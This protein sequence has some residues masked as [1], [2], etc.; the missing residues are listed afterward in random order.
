MEKILVIDD[1]KS[2][3]DLLSVVFEKEGYS[4][5]TSLSATKAV[6][7]MGDEDFDIIISDI[8]MPKMSG[9]ELL[10]YVRENR[11]DIPIV[12]ITAY[13]TIKQAVEALKAGA[14]DYIVKPFDVEELKIIVAQGLEKKRLICAAKNRLAYI[15]KRL[16]T[17]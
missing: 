17:P 9:M 7:L 5:K 16:I 2:I 10:R 12:M 11:P 3:L 15:P 6:E 8:K 14:M 4:V 1:E 13:G